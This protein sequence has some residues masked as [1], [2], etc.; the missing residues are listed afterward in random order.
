VAS[1][2]CPQQDRADR[3][4]IVAALD[5]R[6]PILGCGYAPQI[7]FHVSL[8]DV[9]QGDLFGFAVGDRHA[10]DLFTQENA[11]GMMAKNSV[12]EIREEGFRLI[13]PVMDDNVV[14]RLSA[15]FGGAALRVLE[16]MCHG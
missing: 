4:S 3:T 10:K 13:E 11:L 16:W 6:Q 14:F 5:L 8:T 15:E 1:D 12:S 9:R 7:L 2:L